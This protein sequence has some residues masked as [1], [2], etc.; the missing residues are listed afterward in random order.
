MRHQSDIKPNTTVNEVLKQS[1]PMVRWRQPKHLENCRS[2]QTWKE[3]KSKQRCTTNSKEFETYPC[4]FFETEPN[5][6]NTCIEDKPIIDGREG[7]INV[8]NKQITCPDFKRKTQILVLKI[9]TLRQREIANF[10]DMG[11]NKEKYCI[12]LRGIIE[13]EILKNTWMR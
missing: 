11:S 12:L 9:K 2:Q 3:Q 4:R 7:D 8:F 5:R 1:I 10:N 13:N 6:S